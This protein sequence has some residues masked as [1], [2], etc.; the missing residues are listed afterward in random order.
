MA[1]INKNIIIGND[2]RANK[3]R[4]YLVNIIKDLLTG[5][6]YSFNVDYLDSSVN[7]YSIDKIPVAP[8]LQQYLYYSE[9]KEVYNLRSRNTY[10][11]SQADNLTNIGF[12]EYLQDKINSNNNKGILPEIENIRSIE[13]LNCGS[14]NSVDDTT[15]EM[16]IQIQIT[17]IKNNY[18]NTTSI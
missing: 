7:N 16:S 15:C 9:Q 11:S 3:L 4:V 13:C 8:L 12:F 6:D 1:S 17:Y 5:T 2:T 14:I 18:E 10:S